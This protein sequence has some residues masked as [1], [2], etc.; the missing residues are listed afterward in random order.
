MQF[1]EMSAWAVGRLRRLLLGCPGWKRGELRGA[2][3]VGQRSTNEPTAAVA[4]STRQLL[5][6]PVDENAMCCL[7]VVSCR[8]APVTI[9]LVGRGARQ[10]TVSAR[11]GLEGKR[12]I[13]FAVC[14][15]WW[16][17][18]LLLLLLQDASAGAGAGCDGLLAS[19]VRV[20]KGETRWYSAVV[21]WASYTWIADE[22]ATQKWKR[23]RKKKKVTP[24]REKIERTGD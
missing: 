20:K 5:H 18:L 23:E 8:L 11:G 9:R 2:E 24:S 14:W 22:H 12:R 21:R 1:D 15:R 3:R 13:G 7:A 6:R 16:C 10:C 17:W 4:S 19:L